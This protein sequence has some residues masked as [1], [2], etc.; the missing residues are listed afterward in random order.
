MPK[1]GCPPDLLSIT[2]SDASQR[3]EL[4]LKLKSPATSIQPYYRCFSLVVE[5]VK[6]KINVGPPGGRL[7]YELNS[8]EWEGWIAQVWMR[9]MTQTTSDFGAGKLRVSWYTFEVDACFG[10]EGK[11]FALE[12]KRW[13]YRPTNKNTLWNVAFDQYRHLKDA[14]WKLNLKQ[15]LD[16]F[17]KNS[18]HWRR[19]LLCHYDLLVAHFDVCRCLW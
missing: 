6:H 11:L 3:K 2:Y 4:L 13:K 5:T 9:R 19:W 7:D 15:G 8:N 1:S 12:V 16:H 10:R 17:M 14:F 18:C